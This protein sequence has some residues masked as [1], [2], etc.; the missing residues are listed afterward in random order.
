MKRGKFGGL[1][2]W[3]RALRARHY[4]V[5]IDAQGLGR[6][7]AITRLTGAPARI[8]HADAREFARLGYNRAVR[9]VAVHTVDRMLDLLGPIGVPALRDMRLYSSD[10]ARE[11]VT[12]HATLGGAG[13]AVFAPTSRWPGKCW[14]AARFADLARIALSLGVDAVAVIGVN[15][16][17]AQCAPLLELSAREPRVVDLVGGLTIERMC[18]LIERSAVVVSNDSAAAH[19][20]VGFDRPLIA[21]YGPTDVS[22]VGPYGRERDALQHVT[23][24]ERLDHKNEALGRALMD[25]ITL[26]E[27]AQVLARRLSAR[28]PAGDPSASRPAARG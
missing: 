18:A 5:V 27:A 6:S 9:S 26:D 7:A 11:W 21:F 19:I 28:P 24:G 8:G 17:R 25:R 12:S 15:S 16:E 4:D 14:D 10:G 13:Y 3:I 23:P 2:R 20:A 1:M 22:K